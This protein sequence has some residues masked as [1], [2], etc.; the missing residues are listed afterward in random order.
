M[1]GR[2]WTLKKLVRWAARVFGRTLSRSALRRL[3]RRADLTWKKV[4]KILGRADPAKRV[5][6]VAWLAGILEGVRDGEVQLIYIDQSHFHRDM[7]LGYAW[8][9]KGKRIWRRSDC[10]GL[11]ERINWYGAYDHSTGQCLIWHE[12][13]CRGEAT[14]EFLRR[15]KAWRAGQ[16][17]RLVV[18]WDNAPCQ[19]AV[20]VQ[21]EAGLLGIDLMYLPGYSPDLNPIER[22]WDWM[23]EEVTRGHC[24]ATLDELGDACEAFI[25]RINQNPIAVVDRLWPKLNL[26]PEYEAKLSLSA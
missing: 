17:G 20:A 15:V 14:C 21:R 4:K 16:P 18:V 12:G 6:H 8:G 3:L 5:A 11:S 26:D 7:D 22:L 23:R 13:N 2:N 1:P 24:H 9:R 19:R 25:R 10:P